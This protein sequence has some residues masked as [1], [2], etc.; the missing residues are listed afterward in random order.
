[1][2]SMQR[3]YVHYL[4]GFFVFVAP[5][6]VSAATLYMDP[7]ET[8]IYPGDT[9]AVQIRLDTDEGEC[10]NV[11]DGVINYDT[12]ILP[13]DISRG[14]SI[15]PIWVEEPTIDKSN[16]RITFAGGVPNGYCGRIDGDPKLTNV[17][18]EI[19]FQAP[20]FSV[21]FSDRDDMADVTF[22][23]GTQV[24]LNDGAGSKAALRTFG[25]EILVGDK[26]RNEPID[27]WNGR[28]DDDNIPPQEFSITLTK[29]KSIY[30]GEYFVTFNTTDKQS[31][32]DHYEI[33]EEPIDKFQLFLWGAV[34]APWQT[35]KSPYL[36]KDQSLNRTIRVKAVD[37]AGNE[38]IAVLIPPKELRGTS[39]RSYVRI[40]L[41]VAGAL[42][43]LVT[44]GSVLLYRW[45]LKKYEKLETF[46]TADDE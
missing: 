9:I 45:R 29:D 44:F 3:R 28:V 42:V 2:L 33:M 19:L 18:F 15:V 43:L 39:D 23:D 32:L 20:A 1:M 17:I 25:A 31:G 13:V 5:V 35:V 26:P 14:E 7:H 10:I 24:L 16:K 22:D 4:F 36:L 34:G 41:F 37:K 8:E 6:S 38:Y 11:V 40:G 46:D 30:S 12:E 27:E 21:G